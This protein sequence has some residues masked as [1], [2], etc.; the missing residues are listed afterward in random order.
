MADLANT[1]VYTMTTVKARLRLVNTYYVTGSICQTAR[2]WRSPGQAIR[3]WVRRYD[4]KGLSGLADHSR[5]PRTP[6]PDSV[7]HL[8]GDLRHGP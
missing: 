8:S 4:A 1:Q 5:R 6:E 3:K 2:H 7:L